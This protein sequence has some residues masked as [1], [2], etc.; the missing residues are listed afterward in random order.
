MNKSEL[1]KKYFGYDAFRLGQETIIEHVLAG[2]DGLVIMPTGGGKSL[3]FQL[4]ALMLDGV[5]LVVSPLISL[6]KDQVDALNAAGVPAALINSSINANQIIQTQREVLAG[7]IKILYVA[8]ERFAVP[9]F[10]SFLRQIKVSLIAVDEA[11]C[12]SEWG[13]DFRPD[14]RNLRAVRQQ[15]KDVPVLALTATATEQVRRDIV[16]QLNLAGGRIFISSFD[17]PNLSYSVW[18][19]KK[20]FPKIVGLLQAYRNESTIIYCSS[21]KNT[22]KIASQLRERGILARA[23][24]A[25][26]ETSERHEVQEL[27]IRSEIQVVVATIAFGMG[28]DKPDVRLVIHYDLPKSVEGY[29][30][31]TG[32]AGRD[33]LPSRCVLFFSYGDRQKHLFLINQSGDYD[34][35]RKAVAKLDQ[36][37]QFCQ[38][39]GCRRNFLLN[40]F[41]QNY[42]RD[43]C[44][45]CDVC[46]PEL[47]VDEA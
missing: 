33:S 36:V 35:R 29:Y 2:K 3:C 24:H 11:H 6:M 14:Y 13:H 1:L 43:N 25:G 34:E 15:F 27:F 12:I 17:R 16:Q 9:S 19:K 10:A 42:G 20:S 26:L 5:T 39:A 18:P 23:Y 37:I 40:Y 21:R 7:R 41:G 4:P 32:R 30:Q 31:E 8:P 47:R 45:G 28:I 46:E 44:G 22:E 38:T